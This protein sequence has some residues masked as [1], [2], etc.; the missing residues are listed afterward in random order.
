MTA[1]VRAESLTRRFGEVSAVTDLSFVLEAG[2]ITGFLGPNGAGKTTTLR[3]ILGLAAPTSGRA[4]VFD[5]P[6]AELP[7]AALRIGAALEATNFHPGRSGRDHLRMLG[8]AVDVPDS[9]V[10]EVLRLDREQQ[11]AVAPTASNRGCL[12]ENAVAPDGS[13]VSLLHLAEQASAEVVV[14]PLSQLVQS[15]MTC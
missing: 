4:W 5:F 9:R 1:V 14:G 15:T 13:A 8:Q 2:T 11:P 10:D 7:R 3:M 12:H 6:Y